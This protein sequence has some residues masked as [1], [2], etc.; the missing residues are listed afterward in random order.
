[1]KNQNKPE[2]FFDDLMVFPIFGLEDHQGADYQ[3]PSTDW[4]WLPKA[5]ELL[6]SWGFL[7]LISDFYKQY[8]I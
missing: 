3:A 8:K 6:S 1:M 4:G 5:K 2:P 7:E